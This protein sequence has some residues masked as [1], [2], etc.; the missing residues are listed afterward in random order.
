MPQ[1]GVSTNLV[2]NVICNFIWSSTLT[3]HP[4]FDL[5]PALL[6]S[7]GEWFMGGNKRWMKQRQEEW[8]KD[9]T[10]KS[11]LMSPPNISKPWQI[12]SR[13]WWLQLHV[14]SHWDPHI[15]LEQLLLHYGVLRMWLEVAAEGERAPS[16][17]SH[18]RCLKIT[19]TVTLLEPLCTDFFS[20]VV[21]EKG[22]PRPALT[23]TQCR[24]NSKTNDSVVVCILNSPSWVHVFK[25]GLLQSYGEMACDGGGAQTKETSD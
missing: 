19:A 17:L 25:T 18:C 15:A 14:Q 5:D 22:L 9:K 23:M 11:H 16:D 3:R 10:V 7:G 6:G 2:H 13:K 12:H 21:L 4:G 1:L 24:K 8:G 20:S